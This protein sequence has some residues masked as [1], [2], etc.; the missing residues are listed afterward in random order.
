MFNFMFKNAQQ[1]HVDIVALIGGSKISFLQLFPPFIAVG[2]VVES[3][4]VV[5]VGDEDRQKLNAQD[6]QLLQL[7]DILAK[8]EHRYDV[9]AEKKS[10]T[11]M[12]GHFVDE[13]TV[14]ADLGQ[15]FENYFYV[16]HFFLVVQ[17]ELQQIKNVPHAIEYDEGAGYKG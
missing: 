14:V 7:H 9:A 3:G 15:G 6:F 1:F 5:A 13:S 8:I 4:R 16:L 12:E 10:Y 2:R 11:F 17:G